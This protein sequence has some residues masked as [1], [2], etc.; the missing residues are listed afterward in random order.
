[1]QSFQVA[2]AVVEQDD[3][4]LLVRNLRRNGDHDWTTPGGVVDRG[5]TVLEG[6]TREVNEET[7]LVVKSWS[8]SLYRVRV[9]FPERDWVMN[10][11]AHQALEWSGELVVDD[12]DGIVVEADFCGTAEAAR[13]LHESPRWVREPLLAWTQRRPSAEPSYFYKVE[14]MAEGAGGRSLVVK[15]T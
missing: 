14:A 9:E 15:R 8:V 6:L 13:R 2:G 1:V 3:Q 11:S 5:E 12:P 7:G 10:V 4:L